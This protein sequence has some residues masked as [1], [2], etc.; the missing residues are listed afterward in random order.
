MAVRTMKKV[1]L[2]AL[3]RDR[4]A[5]LQALQRFGGLEIQSITDDEEALTAKAAV[6]RDEIKKNYEVCQD[7]LNRVDNLLSALSVYVTSEK[8]GFMAPKP[9][10]GLSEVEAV[11]DKEQSILKE[12]GE[13][14]DLLGN[15]RELETR[16]S[17][18][19]GQMEQLIPYEALCYPVE[20]LNDTRETHIAVGMV[21][22]TELATL[23][24]EVQ[25]QDLWQLDVIAN[26]AAHSYILMVAHKSLVEEMNRALTQAGF[27]RASFPLKH[28]TCKEMM[29]QLIKEQEAAVKQQRKLEEQLSGQPLETLKVYYDALAI[30]A[31]RWEQTLR[32]G[33]TEAVFYLK[34][35]VP[36]K[37]A[38]KLEAAV[39][40]GDRCGGVI[41]QRSWP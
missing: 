37:G 29:S 23:K 12:I 7:N 40:R 25:S 5:M 2:I 24:A 41:H 4:N 3:E 26:D 39:R 15:I 21:A 27:S 36:A 11:L 9:V 10:L 35:W 1:S 6:N 8:G 30:L 16:R 28:G 33:N 31:Q 20:T 13:A 38:D 18:L 17:H 14:E 34:G 22:A 32:L 19:A